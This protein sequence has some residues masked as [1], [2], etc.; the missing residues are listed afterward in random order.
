MD[1]APLKKKY[2]RAIENLEY[3]V[4]LNPSEGRA[5]SNLVRAHFETGNHEKT[6]LSTRA[7][8]FYNP[9]H[10][11][12]HSFLGNYYLLHRDFEAARKEFLA[13][14]QLEPTSA[15]FAMNS[16]LAYAGLG[17]G[18]HA[19]SCYHKAEALHDSALEQG[20]REIRILLSLNSSGQSN[21]S[22]N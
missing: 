20:L 3:S 19:M 6:K 8:L 7:G 14:E 2:S 1:D 18:N 22:C 4:S 5:W 11:S 15:S 21:V 17:D 12:L 9:R 16:A 13:A 10:A